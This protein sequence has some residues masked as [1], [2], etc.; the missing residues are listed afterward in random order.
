M[1]DEPIRET[2]RIRHEVSRRY[3]HDVHKVVAYYRQFQDELKSAGKYRFFAK[4]PDP[5][6][7]AREHSCE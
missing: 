3:N 2:R 6:R 7:A 4:P 5:A 1:A